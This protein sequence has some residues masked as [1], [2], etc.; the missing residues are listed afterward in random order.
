[1]NGE[2][3]SS[4]MDLGLVRDH[5]TVVRKSGEDQGSDTVNAA[6]LPELDLMEAALWFGVVPISLDARTDLVFVENGAMTAHRYILEYLEPHVVTY[7]P[8][9]SKRIFS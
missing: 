9:I 2:A 5:Q 1:M 3:F 8:F 4:R 7:E 6:Y